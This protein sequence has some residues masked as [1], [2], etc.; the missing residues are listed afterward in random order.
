M[1]IGILTLPLHTNYGGIMQA[2]AL[3]QVLNRLGHEAVL[4]NLPITQLKKTEKAKEYVKRLIKNFL[5]LKPIPLNA[6]P[7]LKE[8]AIIAQH[9]NPFIQQ[10][11]S[12]IECSDRKDLLSLTKKE[13]I[14]GYVVGSDQVWRPFY[15]PSVSSFF[16]DFLD[17]QNIRRVS[18]AAS[19][20]IDSWPFSDDDSAKFG[21]LIKKF[22]AVSLRED[23]AVLLCKKYWNIDACLVLDPTL[24]LDKQDYIKLCNIKPDTT[25]REVMVYI[26]DKSL[27]KTHIANRVS[28]LVGLPVVNVM[29]KEIYWNVG[30]RR[31]EDCVVPPISEWVKGFMDAEFVV[32]DS[33]HG[34]VFSILFRK[35]FICIGNKNRGMTRFTS[36]LR[37]LSLEERLIYSLDDLSIETIS[38]SIDYQNVDLVLHEERNKSLQFLLDAL[39]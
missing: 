29:A 28:E 19:F 17:G 16:L 34:M 6:W 15:S 9:I 7:N 39:N 8:R 5:L 23:S 2:Y 38:N 33:F 12:V 32:T 1:K 3:Q 20:G 11:L 14:E 36:L 26:L 27:E 31:L 24:L 35:P 4:I 30:S 10:N 25:N 21:E 22:D 13:K 18:Y 37:L